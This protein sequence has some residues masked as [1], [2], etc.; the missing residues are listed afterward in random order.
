MEILLGENSESN[1]YLTTRVA[2]PDD[3]WLHA[4]QI[5]GAHV[6]IRSG[7]KGLAIPQSTLRQAAE[8]AAQNSDAKHSSLVPVDYTLKKHVRKPR[9]A[10]PG[11]V[12]YS[13]EKTIDVLP[14]E[15]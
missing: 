12:T 5:K 11:Y 15:R 2:R 6:V 9:G 3:V 10:A 4:R 14:G 1:D 8:L 13:H 7:K